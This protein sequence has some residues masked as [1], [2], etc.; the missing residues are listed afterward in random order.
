M[1]FSIDLFLYIVRVL[2]IIL[3]SL[4]MCW[5]LGGAV[6]LDRAQNGFEVG[7]G[8]SRGLRPRGYG[9]DRLRLETASRPSTTETAPIPSPLDEDLSNTDAHVFHLWA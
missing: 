8:G 4:I 9:V 3:H 1:P 7:G 6:G 2:Q 5:Q